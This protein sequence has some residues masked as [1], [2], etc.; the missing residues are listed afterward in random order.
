MKFDSFVFFYYEGQDCPRVIH[1]KLHEF[2]NKYK[3]ECHQNE[4]SH[5]CSDSDSIDTRLSSRYIK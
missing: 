3:V 5:N 2:P 4:C 1:V